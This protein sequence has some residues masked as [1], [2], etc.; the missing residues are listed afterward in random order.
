MVLLELEELAPFGVVL[1]SWVEELGLGKPLAVEVVSPSSKL[2]SGLAEE[3]REETMLDTP[4]G[5]R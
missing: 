4:F 3:E 5:C 2:H 1:D